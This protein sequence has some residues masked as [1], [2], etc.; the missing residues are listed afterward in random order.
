MINEQLE[1]NYKFDFPSGTS[2]E[3]KII[4]DAE[5]LSYVSK[6]KAILPGWSKLKFN[7]CVRCTLPAKTK[8]CPVAANLYPIMKS[9]KSCNFQEKLQITLDT[10]DRTYTKLTTLQKG[11]SS[12]IGIIMVTSGCPILSKL[13]PM[14]RFHLPFANPQENL[15]RAIS[16]FLV[17]EFFKYKQGLKTDWNLHDLVKTYEEIHQVNVALSKRLKAVDNRDAEGNALIVLDNLANYVNFSLDHN[18][19]AGLEN[20]FKNL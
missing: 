19:L 2:K 12:M 8:Y 15:Y 5:T 18:R 10:T 14:A 13:K 11:V 16:M 17:Q 9:F 20:L 6:R 7:Q 3:F 1:Y 4:L